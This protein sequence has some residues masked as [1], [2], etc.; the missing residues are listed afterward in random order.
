ML[1]NNLSFSKPTLHAPKPPLI[2]PPLRS[3]PWFNTSEKYSDIFQ[4]RFSSLD[5]GMLEEHC[6]ECRGRRRGGS[7]LIDP[8]PHYECSICGCYMKEISVPSDFTED[9][10]ASVA[11]CYLCAATIQNSYVEYEHAEVQY[12]IAPQEAKLQ[13]S[14]KHH[15]SLRHWLSTAL[16][17]A[18]EKIFR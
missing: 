11:T 8:R 7:M 10:K 18:Y 4:T 13:E 3:V 12:E 9:G 17:K 2:R 14:P 1:Q 15:R 5:R 6:R 16:S